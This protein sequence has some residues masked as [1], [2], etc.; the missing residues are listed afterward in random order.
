MGVTVLVF[1]LRSFMYNSVIILPKL[2]KN[3]FTLLFAPSIVTLWVCGKIL[4]ASA[5][6]LLP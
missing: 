1:S 2:S 6:P 5:K 3:D 4:N